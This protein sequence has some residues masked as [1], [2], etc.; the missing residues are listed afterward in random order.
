[1]AADEGLYRRNT[2]DGTATEGIHRTVNGQPEI[3]PWSS[4]AHVHATLAAYNGRMI[5]VIRIGFDDGRTLL[6]GEIEPGWPEIVG[7]LHTHLAIEPYEHWGPAFSRTPK[8]MNCSFARN[9]S[10]GGNRTAA[11]CVTSRGVDLSCA[12]VA[13]GTVLSWER[14]WKGHRC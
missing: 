12:M 10:A 8:S 6:L 4:V 3:A 2:L 7:A 11:W 13:T 1:M 14:Y 5:F 9:L